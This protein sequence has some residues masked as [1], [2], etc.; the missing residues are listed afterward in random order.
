MPHGYLGKWFNYKTGDYDAKDLAPQTDAEAKLYIPQHK[1]VQG[2]FE[3]RRFMGD[4][5]LEAMAY[6][7]GAALPKENKP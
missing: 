7:L 5:I 2:I 6:A 1:A 4:S 3:C